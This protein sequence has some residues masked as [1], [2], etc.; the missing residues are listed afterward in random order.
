MLNLG[1]TKICLHKSTDIKLY[2][3]TKADKDL[4]EKPEKIFLVVLTSFLHANQIL[5]KIQLE[6]LRTYANQLLGLILAI[7]IHIRCL[8]LSLY[9]LEPRTGDK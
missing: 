2:P 3:C 6:S 4:L 5:M 9:T 8:N 7:F 1:C